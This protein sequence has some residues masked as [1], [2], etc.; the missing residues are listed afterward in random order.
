M[1]FITADTWREN[2]IEV[3]IADGV[4]WLNETKI[5]EQIG[6]TTLRNVVKQYSSNLRKQRQDLIK[7]G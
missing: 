3:I 5:E 7:T 1:V 2:G 4:K 6:Y